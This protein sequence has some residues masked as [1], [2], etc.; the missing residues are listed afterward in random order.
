MS[1]AEPRKAY[2]DVEAA[3]A[4]LYAAVEAA[5]LD[6]MAELWVAGPLGDSSVCVHPGWAPLKGRSRVL[7]AWALIMAN[8]SYIQFF[9]TDIETTVSGDIGTV[10]CVENILTGVGGALADGIEGDDGLPGG[11]VAA[12]NV[13]RRTERGWKLWL[14]HASPVMALGDTVFDD[15]RGAAG[16]PNDDE[17]GA[18]DESN[19][20][21]PN[22]DEPSA[23]AGEGGA[24]R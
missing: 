19:D 21:G 12:T 17:P 1:D 15:S 16:E 6:A 3:N 9:L 8:T 24:G 22:H 20:D 23:E 14:H 11:Q 18:A 5:D 2:V 7:R 4:A 13:F 10:T